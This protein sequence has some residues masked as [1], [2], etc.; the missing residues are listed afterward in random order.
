[1]IRVHTG[2]NKNVFQHNVHFLVMVHYF[3]NFTNS[4]FLR[5]IETFMLQ[6]IPYLWG[7]RFLGFLIRQR[8]NSLE[9][10]YG[11]VSSVHF[12]HLLLLFTYS[13]RTMDIE[14]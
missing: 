12:R 4:I 6:K 1:M 11:T 9:S 14:K 3:T 13:S 10:Y 2:P 8:W 7:V 5:E